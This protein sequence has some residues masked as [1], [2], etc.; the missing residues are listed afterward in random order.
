LGIVPDRAH[1]VG[2]C[3]TAVDNRLAAPATCQTQHVPPTRTESADP[4]DGPRFLSIP[5]VAD[6]LNVSVSQVYAL[7]RNKEI[8][9]IRIGGRGQ[10]RIERVELEA[11]IQRMYTET[12]A[13]LDAHPFAEAE[14]DDA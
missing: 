5:D 7:V 3:W 1:H 2:R 11:Y 9:T 12:D 14:R 6:V 13:Y 8:K 4:A 10:Y